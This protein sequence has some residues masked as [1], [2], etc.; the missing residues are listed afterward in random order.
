MLSWVTT[1]LFETSKYSYV[2]YKI[3]GSVL[4]LHR[5]H[6]LQLQILLKL[7]VKRILKIGV[8]ILFRLTNELTNILNMNYWR[9]ESH[10]W[11]AW[12]F[13]FTRRKS[14]T[15]GFEPRTYR[16]KSK[17]I[18]LCGY[19]KLWLCADLV[20]YL[21]FTLTNMLVILFLVPSHIRFGYVSFRLLFML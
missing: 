11:N 19:W 14:V 3:S 6:Q 17:S 10:T 1:V 12:I 9:V 20:V 7:R 16:C 21:V 18:T 5:C 13:A 8:R 2:C 4:V 15:L